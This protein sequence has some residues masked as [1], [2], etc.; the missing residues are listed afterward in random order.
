MVAAFALLALLAGVGP[1]A[2]WLP[3]AVISGLLLLVAWGL[4]DR[5]EIRR[6][7]REEPRERATLAVTFF[8]TIALSLEWAILL[9]LATA[10]ISHRLVPAAR[11]R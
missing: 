2:R 5:P 1:L 8:A 10:L 7:W 3:L 4:I 11:G 9:G 6:I